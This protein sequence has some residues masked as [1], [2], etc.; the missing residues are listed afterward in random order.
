MVFG[1][2]VI[3][4]LALAPAAPAM[5]QTTQ[6]FTETATGMQRP[7]SEEEVGCQD[8][9]GPTDGECTSV[10]E[11]SVVGSPIT[12]PN[13]GE[14]G[15]PDSFAGFLA[16]LMVDYSQATYTPTTFSAPTTGEA[17]LQEPPGLGDGDRITLDL[18][19][20]FSGNNDGTGPTTFE[21]TFTVTGGSGRFAGA[22]GSGDLT[23]TSENGRFVAELDGTLILP[24]GEE[25]PPPDDP[26]ACDDGRDNDGDGRTDLRDPGCENSRDDS[27]RDPRPNPEPDNGC[28]V[29]GNNRDNV[30]RGTDKRDVICARGGED[31]I[32]GR[33]GNDLILGGNGNDTIQGNK[34]DDTVKGQDG[35]DTIQ[36]N[37]GRDKLYGGGG[38]DTIQG[39]NGKDVVRGGTGRDATQH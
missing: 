25:P 28:T 37:D 6:P 38:E 22:T 31:T 2:A 10:L 8:P 7:I 34:G 23:A 5:A 24:G 11:G 30:L 32:Q 4:A 21:G 36:G 9:N 29:T 1:L 35:D 13:D 14:G 39:G 15:G 12:N 19:G 27:E 20:T 17:H 18:Q 26:A 16:I 3:L 33:G